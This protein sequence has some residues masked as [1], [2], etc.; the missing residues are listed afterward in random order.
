MTPLQEMKLMA[1][2]GERARLS[3]TAERDALAAQCDEG[4]AREKLSAERIQFY[5]EGLAAG[6]EKI[7][8]LEQNL[9]EAEKKIDDTADLLRRA[10]QMVPVLQYNWHANT[11][12]LLASPGCAQCRGSKKVQISTVCGF[13]QKTCP[14]CADGEKP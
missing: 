12:A 1:E 4:L 13:V 11:D 2:A 7:K 6:L 8:G 9:A 5:A 10:K 14:G 3:L